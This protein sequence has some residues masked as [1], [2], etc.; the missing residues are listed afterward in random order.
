M[1]CSFFSW[2]GCLVWEYK[3]ENLYN[4]VYVNNKGDATVA[5]V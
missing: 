4:L 1:D 3:L 2:R 5:L